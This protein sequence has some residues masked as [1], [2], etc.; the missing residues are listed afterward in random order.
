MCE[1]I[2]VSDELAEAALYFMN[3]HVNPLILHA[4]DL[5]KVANSKNISGR[6]RVIPWPHIAAHPQAAS[7]HVPA[8]DSAT[9]LPL[10]DQSFRPSSQ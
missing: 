4:A 9:V 2:V 7:L 1:K 10:L 8:S 6:V 3:A 5:Q